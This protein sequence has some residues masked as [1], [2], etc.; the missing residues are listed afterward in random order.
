MHRNREQGGNQPLKCGDKVR[1]EQILMDPTPEGFLQHA[2]VGGLV[3]LYPLGRKPLNNRL[4]FPHAKARKARF[5][6]QY[7]KGAQEEAF[8]PL[9]GRS[10]ALGD[11]PDKGAAVLGFP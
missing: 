7:F 5:P 8:D 10:L 2:V 11:L 6:L 3:C 1:A 9:P 4:D